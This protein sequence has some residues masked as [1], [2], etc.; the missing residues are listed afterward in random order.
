MAQNFVSFSYQETGFQML[1]KFSACQILTN[2]SIKIGRR[3]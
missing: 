1:D 3:A 2:Q